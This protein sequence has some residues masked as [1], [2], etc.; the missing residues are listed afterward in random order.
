MVIEMNYGCE[1]TPQ[2]RL[3][4]REITCLRNRYVA[5][6]QHHA[7]SGK[8]KIVAPY[9]CQLLLKMFQTVCPHGPPIP[10]VLPWICHLQ[11]EN[12]PEVAC[13]CVPGGWCSCKPKMRPKLLVAVSPGGGGV[14]GGWCSAGLAAQETRP[15]A[16][17]L[18]SC[19]SSPLRGGRRYGDTRCHGDTQTLRQTTWSVV[20]NAG[21]QRASP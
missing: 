9:A 12:A 16:H 10:M 6:M 14:P 15:R 17:T 8:L 2:L 21:T 18:T 3:R 7:E 13:S 4:K 11:T 5:E 1:N 19:G 20:Q